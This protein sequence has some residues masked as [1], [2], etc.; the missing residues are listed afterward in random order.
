MKNLEIVKKRL[1]KDCL[2]IC[3]I[4]AFWRLKGS[5]NHKELTDLEIVKIFM[6]FWNWDSNPMSGYIL[7][8]HDILSKED[9]QK[10]MSDIENELSREENIEI[11]RETFEREIKNLDVTHWLKKLK[12]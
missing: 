4:P 9:Y 11:L 3:S 2:H 8:L 6:D 10:L 5:K 12:M 1:V 7:A